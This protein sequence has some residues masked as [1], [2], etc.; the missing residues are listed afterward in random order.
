MVLCYHSFY[1]KVLH[2]ISHLSV[3]ITS[4][5]TQPRSESEERNITLISQFWNSKIVHKVESFGYNFLAI[6]HWY[7]F[8][9]TFDL[10]NNLEI[11]S[12]FLKTWFSTSWT[13]LEYFQSYDQNSFDILFWPYEIEA[14]DPKFPKRL[15]DS[16]TLVIMNL[17][18]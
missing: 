13:V 14:F 7:K 3:I 15:L 8:K 10:M 18:Y 11:V 5:K 4:Y 16:I 6:K 9:N 1:I 2:P 12:T 17:T